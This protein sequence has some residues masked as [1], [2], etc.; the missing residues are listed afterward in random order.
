MIYAIYETIRKDKLQR[1]L[2]FA[3][4]ND[5]I[6]FIQHLLDCIHKTDFHL[7]KTLIYWIFLESILHDNIDCFTFLLDTFPTILS[8]LFVLYHTVNIP[9]IYPHPLVYA[10]DLHHTS[11]VQFRLSCEYSLLNINLVIAD[12]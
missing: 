8:S 7:Y 3:L 12:C 9:C 10:V 4:F 2:H 5:D 6:L 11:I 1:L